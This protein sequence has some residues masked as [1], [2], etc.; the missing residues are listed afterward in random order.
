MN[1]N[2]DTIIPEDNKVRLVC[3][4][5]E[6]MDLSSLSSTY[7]SKGRKSVLDPVTFLKVLLFCFNEGIFYTR[8]IEDF[9][10]YDIRGRF[11]LGGRKAPDH[12]TICR[13]QNMRVD[14]MQDL[15]TQFIEILLE[16]GHVDL[17]SIYIDGTKIEAVANRYTFVWRKSV[18]KYQTKLKE[19]MIKELNMPEDSSLLEVISKVNMEFNKIRNK[20]SEMKIQFVYG[21]GCSK[22]PQQRS[23]EYYQNVK[24]K[25][26]TYQKHLEIMGA[27]NSYSKTDHD[28][29]FMSMKDDHMRNGQ[30][31]PAY[32]IQLATSG[33]FIVGVMGS[34]YANDM[35]TLKPFLNQML[36]SYGKYI[37]NI[38]ADAGYES[39]ENYAYLKSRKLNAYIKP[40]NH[41]TKKKKK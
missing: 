40:A 39:A 29:T 35:Y 20:C 19:R 9:C 12:T 10:K 21:K 8:K 7:S 5:V 34:Q 1:F 14:H 22:T 36:P 27:R 30:L 2:V 17:K 25:F 37:E 23:Y 18:E 4:I 13:F 26:E 33:A 6:R 16:E 31:K 41:E 15:L 38:V 32:N 11:L 3:N 28:A 24:E